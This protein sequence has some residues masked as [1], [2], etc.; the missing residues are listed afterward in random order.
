MLTLKVVWPNDFKNYNVYTANRYGVYELAN[1]TTQ[2]LINSA[3]PDPIDIR[4]SEGA[5]VYVM[6]ANG[7][8]VDVI[9]ERRGHSGLM[10]PVSK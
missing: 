9:T 8:T 6:N 7:A 10:V 2:L 3:E 1:D 5:I 4:L